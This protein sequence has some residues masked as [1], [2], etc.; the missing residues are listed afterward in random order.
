MMF[1]IRK[2]IDYSELFT[3]RSITDNSDSSNEKFNVAKA[4]ATQFGN[5]GIIQFTI[6]ASFI[7]YH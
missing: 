5:I 6:I 2:K 3:L 7:N 4:T 1:S